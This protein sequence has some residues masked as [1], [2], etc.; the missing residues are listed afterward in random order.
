ME[1][2][3]HAILLKVTI[4]PVNLNACFRVFN[5]LPWSKAEAEYDT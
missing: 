4:R 3:I 1:D 5:P 2:H